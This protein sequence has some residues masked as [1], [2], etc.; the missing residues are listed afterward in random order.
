MPAHL[1][2]R[3]A[4]AAAL[5]ASG[6]PWPIAPESPQAC[7]YWAAPTPEGDDGNPG[8]F[9]QPWATL[10]HASENMPDDTCTVW[11]KDGVYTGANSLY[12]RFT[13]LTTFKAVNA[14]R[15][16]FQNSG[17]AAQLFGA[18]NMT[19]EGLVFQ[20][21]G[22]GSSGL[23]VQVQKSDDLWSENI[24][25]RDNIFHDSY[26][27]D[28][29]KINNGARFVTV[30]NNVF[31]NQ[32][33]SDEHMDVNSVT[34]VTVQDNIFFNDFAGSGRVNANDTSS[35]IVIKD[36]NAGDD[37]QVGSERIMVRRNVFL[38]WEGS[39]GSN[40]VLVGEDGQPFHEA[41]VV[42]VEN[43]LMIGNAG[44]DM[45]AAFGVKGGQD[46]TF[47]NNTVVGDLPAL[48]YALRVNQEGSNPQN[49]D[50]YFYN[51]IWADPTGTMG[52]E[53]AGGTNEFSDGSP[54]EVS[55]LVLDNNLYWNGGLPIPPGDLVSPL[56]DDARRVVADPLL[57]TDHTAIVLPRWNGSTFLSGNTTI[58]QE[59][60]RLVNLYGQIPSNSP[61]I[62]GADPAFAPTDD[63][64]GRPRTAAPDLGSYQ[65]NQWALSGYADLTTI[66]LNW[67]DPGVPGAA[68]LAITYTTGTTSL[69]VTDLLT[70]TRAY[71]LTNLMPYS[72]YTVTLTARDASDGILAQTNSIVLL[73]SDRHL[74]LPLLTNRGP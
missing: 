14:Y 41:K 18:Y 32:Q 40:F 23:V 17:P 27:N 8:T 29:L 71:T 7:E 54:D 74:Y 36:S 13:T 2:L 38:N 66:W 10:D 55:N 3:L 50:I 43:N 70:T 31:Y 34:D 69:L 26:N 33:G 60:E 67:T 45:R 22:P 21:T 51:N 72:L 73:T 44:N 68:S 19:F 12:E 65:G 16:I 46:I 47:R 39:S 62:G 48:A 61:A 52:A 49:Q 35:F 63:I 28:L 9:D 53:A 64:L 30:E 56:V 6:I 42:L 4:L 1:L 25:F 5:V 24:T 20:H 15:A 59:F 58:R 37:G 11:F 57:N